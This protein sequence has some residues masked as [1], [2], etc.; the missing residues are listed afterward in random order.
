MVSEGPNRKTYVASF[1]VITAAIAVSSALTGVR[2]RRA[3]A[4]LSSWHIEANG[5]IYKLACMPQNR[6]NSLETLA[7]FPSADSVEGLFSN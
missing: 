7:G 4:L 3:E 1:A 5:V 2:T 6:L